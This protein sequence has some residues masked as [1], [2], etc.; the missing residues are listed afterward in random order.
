MWKVVEFFDNNPDASIIE[1]AKHF[2]QELEIKKHVEAVS[3]EGDLVAN[4]RMQYRPLYAKKKNLEEQLALHL[5]DIDMEVFVTFPPRQGSKEERESLRNK[6][7]KE[8]PDY[9]RLTKEVKDVNIQLEELND[10]I[11]KADRKAKN[12]RRIIELFNGYMGMIMAYKNKPAP[13]TQ[14]APVEP[15]KNRLF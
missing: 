12:G 9:Q 4:A 10:D 2:E 8:H 15:P 11:D 5:S 3:K 7:K 14:Q 1:A 13:V 6:L